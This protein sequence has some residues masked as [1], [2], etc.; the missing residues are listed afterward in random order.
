MLAK[1]N[2]LDA[3]ILLRFAQEKKLRP[4]PAP[5]PTQEALVALLDR[6]SHLSEQLAREKN[7]LQN[8]PALL[9][10]SIQEMVA[11]VEVKLREI[12]QRIRQII[13]ADDPL[14]SRAARI[15]SVCGIGEITAW[16]LL[17]Y[18][19]EIGSLQRTLWWH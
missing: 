2:R 1:T 7:R 19:S 14:R 15:Q 12:D 8:S 4:T 5:S 9:H 11:F 3:H 17:A 6:R 13:Q 10:A 18:L 16:T